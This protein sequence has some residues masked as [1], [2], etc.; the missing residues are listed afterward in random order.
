MLCL[1][2]LVF[3]VHFTYRCLF[4]TELKFWFEQKYKYIYCSL[5][6]LPDFIRKLQ[7]TS[8]SLFVYI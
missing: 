5:V 8:L 4:G 2:R 1:I 6:I 7:A 3:H